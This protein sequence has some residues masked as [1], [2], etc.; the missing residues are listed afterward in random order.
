MG[1]PTINKHNLTDDQIKEE[2]LIEAQSFED[3]IHDA[4]SLRCSCGDSEEGERSC[5][6][7]NA[8]CRAREDFRRVITDLFGMRL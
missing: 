5:K 8:V 1:E 4:Y 3:A 6:H 7:C 2:I